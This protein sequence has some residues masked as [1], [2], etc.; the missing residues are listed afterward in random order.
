M[1]NTLKHRSR[2]ELEAML[3]LLKRYRI[4]IRSS[5]K[6]AERIFAAEGSDTVSIRVEHF[7]GLS[8]GDAETLF[9]TLFA[10]ILAVPSST[11]ISW[12]E[13]PELL[14]GMRVF[15]GDDLYDMSY[16]EAVSHLGYHDTSTSLA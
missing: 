2:E 15:V 12:S 10:D 13:N 3:L 14:G 4:M 16:R 5:G 8:R 7:S 1:E 11:S 6:R 9:R